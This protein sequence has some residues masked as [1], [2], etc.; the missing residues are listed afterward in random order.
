MTG[1]KYISQ[2]NQVV[3]LM[4][5]V[6]ILLM[7]VGH[8]GIP[9]EEFLYKFIY[10]FHMPLFFIIAG[11]YAKSG[12]ET[13]MSFL[14]TLKKDFKRLMVPYIV[15][16]IAIVLFTSLRAIVQQDISLVNERLEGLLYVTYDAGPIWFLM[17]LFLIRS[18]FRPIMKL[19]KWAL[20][21][22]VVI[23]GGALVIAHH[24]TQLPFCIL[25][26]CAIMVF[27][28][29]GWYYKKYG[30][31]MW[32]IAICVLCWPFAIYGPQIDL[33]Y[34]KFAIYPLTV[35]GACGGT[36][37]IY[38]VC[39]NI[40]KFVNT[41]QNTYVRKRN[42]RRLPYVCMYVCMYAGVH[43]L[44][45]LCFHT[46]D[47]YC[48]YVTM[49]LYCFGITLPY[50]PTIFIRDG[51]VLLLSFLYVKFLRPIWNKKYCFR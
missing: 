9:K 3:D 41:D 4:K 22:S 38:K 31:P 32:F 23:S 50:W 20:P 27:Y 37:V 40:V 11:Y 29:F 49:S 42:R 51:L 17:C 26:A 44:V 12:E 25:T 47:M 2:R 45:I 8:T 1:D 33:Y 35:L 14:Q 43:S 36:F 46:F 18:F 28:A 7:L 19:G 21:F 15:T 10:S 48:N 24:Y 13:G 39:E 6:A 5:G 30:M 16:S 34:M